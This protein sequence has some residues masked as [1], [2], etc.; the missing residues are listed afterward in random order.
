M[1]N[2]PA[3]PEPT[4]DPNSLRDSVLALKQA[5]EILSG[6]KG[7]A[8]VA[9]VTADAAAATN[10]TNTVAMALKANLVSPTFT[11]PVI[12]NS[13]YFV[14][15][16]SNACVAFDDR[17]GDA[18]NAWVTYAQTNQ[19]RVYNQND[20]TDW[21]TITK[22][23]GAATFAGKIASSKVASTGPQFDIAGSANVPFGGSST[24]A[25][26]FPGN[27]GNTYALCMVS[28]P[29]WSGGSGL[30][31]LS[32]VS[33]ILVAG[34]TTFVASTSTPA[35]SCFSVHYDGTNWR[36]YSGTGIGTAYVRVLV[37]NLF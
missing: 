13:G 1:A 8:G 37:I 11:G 33:A 34:S 14:T 9:A 3:I 26:I 15:A 23:T 16:G 24:S 5:F 30:Y 12:A 20:T 36:L 17:A 22:A 32:N 2:Y 6:Q 31:I 29:S 10:A 4:N 27:G 28:D 19:F 18:T 25:I 21:L 35:A 7:V